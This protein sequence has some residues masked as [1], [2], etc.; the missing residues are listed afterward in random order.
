[1]RAKHREP[2]LREQA[3]QRPCARVGE[4]RVGRIGRLEPF[5]HGR[6]EFRVRKSGSERVER[7]AGIL[8]TGLAEERQLWCV[9][10]PFA[11]HDVHD[12]AVAAQNL[13]MIRFGKV[14]VV[15]GHPEHRHHRDA[16]LPLELSCDRDRR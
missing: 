1:M 11:Q 16:A 2:A 8:A 4:I 13:G 15:A 14:V 5:E 12:F 7:R 9:V 6:L 3:V 10:R